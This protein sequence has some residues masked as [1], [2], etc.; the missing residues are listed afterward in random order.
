MIYFILVICIQSESKYT[1]GPSHTYKMLVFASIST[2][3][4][5]S[6]SKCFIRNHFFT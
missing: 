3:T 6:S 5:F 1:N 2:T 4:C